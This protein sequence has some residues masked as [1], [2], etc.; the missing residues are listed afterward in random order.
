MK[1]NIPKETITTKAGFK[2]YDTAKKNIRIQV[3]REFKEDEKQKAEEEAANRGDSISKKKRPKLKKKRSFTECQ[4]KFEDGLGLREKY[5]FNRKGPNM[6]NGYTIIEMRKADAFPIQ[7]E[8]M[9]KPDN[10][11]LHIDTVMHAA[12]HAGNVTEWGE[13]K[14]E[15]KAPANSS[16]DEEMVDIYYTTDEEKPM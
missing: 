1:T 3:I 9:H 8:L 6:I 16:E 11:K 12:Y 5:N 14:D 4:M 2:D 15:L 10:Y 13:Y 7:E